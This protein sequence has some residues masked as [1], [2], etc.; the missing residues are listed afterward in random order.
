MLA[1]DRTGGNKLHT[2]R[3]GYYHYL[4]RLSFR[5][6]LRVYEHNIHLTGRKGPGRGIYVAVAEILL[7]LSS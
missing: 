5:L 7:L 4:S 1:T 2:V 6:V 3:G